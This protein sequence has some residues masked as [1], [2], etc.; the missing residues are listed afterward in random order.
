MGRIEVLVC[1]CAI[2][3]TIPQ[4]VLD[5]VKEGLSA[6][7]GVWVVADLCGLAAR[8]DPALLDATSNT[9]LTIVACYPRAVRWL[10]RW[11]G[12]ETVETTKIWNMRTQ[13]AVTILSGLPVLGA[14]ARDSMRQ[15]EKL[16]D[17]TPWFPVID[18]DRCVGCRQCLDFCLFGVYSPGQDRAVQVANPAGCK[19]GC[20]ACARVCPHAAIVFPKYPHSPINGDQVTETNWKACRGMPGE[21]S[22]EHLKEMLAL[23][24]MKKGKSL[25]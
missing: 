13:D 5:A 10:L 19:T 8:R 22:P 15:T 2:S 1:E 24:R 18:Y 21:M 3:H 17:W 20:P 11:A 12:V 4:T 25:I 9:P 14:E 6:R 23:R 16:D 7:R